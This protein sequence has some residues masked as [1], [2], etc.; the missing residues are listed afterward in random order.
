MSRVRFTIDVGAL[1]ALPWKV[2]SRGELRSFDGKLLGTIHDEDAA[3]FIEECARR[4][5]DG[6]I[7]R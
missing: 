1:P 7:I 6:E 2:N 3:T 4:A 5:L